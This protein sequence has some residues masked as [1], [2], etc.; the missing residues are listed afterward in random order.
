MPTDWPPPYSGHSGS[1][2]PVSEL[3]LLESGLLVELSLDDALVELDDVPLLV[4]L[5]PSLVASVAAGSE[6]QPSSAS[7]TTAP[8]FDLQDMAR[9]IAASDRERT[10]YPSGTPRSGRARE[11]PTRPEIALALE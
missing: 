11:W 3:L 8:T 2:A 10:R 7:S 5:P 6:G 4:L 9:T 1:G